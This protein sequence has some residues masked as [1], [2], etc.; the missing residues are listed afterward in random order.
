MHK[1]IIFI[2]HVVYGHFYFLRK[3]TKTFDVT[4]HR[5]LAQRFDTEEEAKAMVKE[6]LE[7]FP[8]DKCYID[9]VLP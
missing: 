1:Y 3:N 8:K 9:P 4:D 6:Y 7:S 2:E 5:N